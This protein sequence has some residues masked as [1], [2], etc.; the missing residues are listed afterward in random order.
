MKQSRQIP[1]LTIFVCLFFSL[2]SAQTDFQR[3]DTEFSDLILRSKKSIVAIGTFHFNTKPT[4]QFAGTGFVIGNGTRIVTNRHVIAAIKEKKRSFNLRVFHQNLPEK[5]VKATLLAEDEFHDL[6]ILKIQEKSL[7]ALPLEK[8]RGVREGHKIAFT[9][10]PIGFILGLNPTTHTGII[11]AIAPIILP[12][13]TARIINGDLIKHL[14]EPF[15]IFQIDGTAYP[16]NSG[17]PV[18]RIATGEVVGVINMVFIKGKKEHVLQEPTGITYA[19]PIE[20]VHKL[21]R[22]IQ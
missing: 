18:Y 12:S 1:I 5:G 11:S 4:V 15:D 7:P 21:N 2:A 20:Y 10:Y 13:P 16:G 8:D 3:E 6:A 19:I 17:S 14:K 9:G 22:S